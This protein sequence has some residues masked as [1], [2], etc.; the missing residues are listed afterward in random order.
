MPRALLSVSDKRGLLEFA[1][2]LSD[3]GFELIAT[4]GT[5]AALQGAG[6]PVISVSE[7]T[8]AAEI[9]DGRVKT[10]HP[11]IHGG[12]LALA[13][14][15]HDA[16]LAEHGIE[17]I[18]VVAVNLYPFEETVA[19]PGVGDA[20][21]MENLDIGGPTMVRAAAKNHAR[22]V[23]VVSP[24]DYP[25]VLDALRAGPVP[26]EQRRSLA[27]AAFAHTAAYDAAIVGYLD[28][29]DPLPPTRH[30]T[31]K[32][33]EVLRYG[34]NPHQLGARYREAGAS[35][36]WDSV[37]QHGGVALSYLNL[38]D[39][40]A[41]W[42]LVHAFEGRPSAVVVKHA[43]PCGVAVADSLAEAYER[44]FDADPKSAFG[45]VVALAGVVNMQLA[46]SLVANPKADVL[47][48]SGY[49]P[50]A[51]GLLLRKRKNMR[52]LE[53]AA[54][55]PERDVWRRIDGGF[56][57]Q[58]P[59]R[60]EQR[61]EGWQVVSERPVPEDL[62]S[63]VAMAWAVCGAVSSNAIVMVQGGRA[64]GIGA[65]Q[66]SRVDAVEIAVRKSA[67]RARGGVVA[68]D[69]FFPFRDGLDAAAAAGVAVVVQ[70][71]GSMRDDEV[72]SAANE[73]GLAMVLTGKRHF[74][75]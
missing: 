49:D 51:L 58:T 10:L 56:L 28:G 59:D 34:E 27:R 11:R 72:I 67:G 7:V 18:D 70:P 36:W 13:T 23:V 63:D 64:V 53:A 22:V 60:I 50:E 15:E 39:A 33:A 30:L 57:G 3:L 65:G 20:E 9:L 6:L 5:K 42:R 31:L 73:H 69:A 24:D 14:A 54:P 32:R 17:R 38:F 47:I 45:G 41:A 4:G 16:V 52:V 12:L 21:A 37:V 43:N 66:Q 44:A 2:G 46:E 19:R 48:A 40:D 35:G 75:H 25:V 62:W 55:Q 61:H 71:G 1:Q 74:R 29:D 68:S 8:G 26:L